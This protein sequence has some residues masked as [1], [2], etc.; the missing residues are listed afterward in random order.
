MLF[1]LPK[2]ASMIWLV[3]VVGA[4]AVLTV[5]VQRAVEDMSLAGFAM[6]F[7]IACGVV[8]RT[9]VRLSSSRPGGEVLY[10]MTTA[11]LVAVML[12]FPMPWA[13]VI[14]GFGIALG[15]TLRGQLQL[16]K[17]AFN[18]GN[19]TLSVSAGSAIYNILGHGPQIGSLA[20]IP[21][22]ALASLTYFALNTGLTAAMVA[23]VLNLPVPLIWRRSHRK[24]LVPN[25]SLLA[26][27]VPIAGLW[28]S[29]QWMLACLAV[30]LMAVHRAMADRVK[31]ET[32]TL[33]SLF[34]L[35]DVLDG[36]DTYTY[37]HS[38]RVG[39]YAEQV[40]LRLGV[41]GERAHLAFLAGR[42]HDIGKCATSNEVLHKPTELDDDEREHMHSHAEIGAAMLAPFSLFSDVAAFV[43]SHHEW[44]DG[45]G[46]PDG[47]QG[48][49][50]PLESR[51]IAVV[52]A[53]DAM[54]TNRPYR[55]ALP[56]L[57]AVRR[58]Q[59]GAG[60]QWDPVVVSSFIVW[61]EAHRLPAP[62]VVRW[63]SFAPEG[64]R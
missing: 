25:L 8:E 53:Y 49:A 17:L 45:A 22:V 39:H 37:G 50:I 32:Q 1:G 63:P 35:A 57:E 19:V 54:T 20:A 44:W 21:W 58:L 55:A 18:I 4:G 26:A 24:V 36:R 16:H 46:Y 10:S 27:G 51:I 7:A 12:L 56:H 61:T 2:R 33:D 23:S 52:D 28:L 9:P 13:A 47:L 62:A 15:C 40:A 34:E 59:A 60:Q 30:G 31:L 6:L 5:A 3:V 48:E 11:V 38:Q 43:R 42:L 64:S 14:A 41:S 29:Y